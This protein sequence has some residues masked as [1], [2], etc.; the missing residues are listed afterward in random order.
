MSDLFQASSLS[1][2][3]P[4]PLADRVRP[5]AL[6]EV[7][8]QDHLLSDAAPLGRML[9][10]GHLTSLILWGPPGVGKTT[11]AR[12]LAQ[13]SALEMSAK[14][15]CYLSTRFTGLINLSK[16]RFCPMLKRGL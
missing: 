5:Q 11:I 8:G 12:L 7:V 6:T 13:H 16:M 15:L 10:S 2:N 4:R 14:G 9:G 1:D 3:A